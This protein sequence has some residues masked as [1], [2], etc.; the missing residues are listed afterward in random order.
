[1]NNLFANIST[2]PLLLAFFLILKRIG[3]LKKD[4]S[5][6]LSFIGF[7]IGLTSLIFLAFVRSPITK[8][9]LLNPLIGFLFSFT[10]FIA[11]LAVLKFLN[12]SKEHRPIFVSSLVTLEG[13]SIGYPF[14]IAIF[15]AQNLSQIALLDLG[16]AVFAFTVLTF[17]FYQTAN[18]IGKKFGDQFV[19]ILKIPLLWAMVAGLV[20][21]LLGMKLDSGNTLEGV[22][23][24]FLENI[25]GI[26]VPLILA[27]LVL[28]LEIKMDS[29][30][31][32]LF[33]SIGSIAIAVILAIVWSLVWKIIPLSL[34]A[35][36]ALFIMALLPP[37]LY[38][39]VL[40]EG[41]N[42]SEHQKNYTARLFSVT[43]FVSIIL[44]III[45][46]FIPKLITLW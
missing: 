24:K 22:L 10:L 7:N 45:S 29:I 18:Q 44:L 12:I 34:F 26:A 36:G 20:L 33:F 17:Y 35:K 1:M 31:N 14:F 37:S 3:V 23:L 46:P 6:P 11:G 16:M 21:N 28:N 9:D 30:K 19:E 42:L 39:F 5:K 40:A 13:G 15:G 32:T 2:L 43:V 8:N 4:W 27:G 38:P 25:G 41:L